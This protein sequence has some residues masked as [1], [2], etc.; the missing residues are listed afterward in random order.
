MK[1]PSMRLAARAATFLVHGRRPRL[2][3]SESHR[4]ARPNQ[5]A[6]LINHYMPSSSGGVQGG[7]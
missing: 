6:G 7:R 4:V 1:T 3:H 2:D 5:H